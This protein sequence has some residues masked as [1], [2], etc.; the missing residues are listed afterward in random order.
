MAKRPKKNKTTKQTPATEPTTGA[1]TGEGGQASSRI[2]DA[3]AA[4]SGD[5][6]DALE[7]T[8]LAGDAVVDGP[9]SQQ[10]SEDVSKGDR[11]EAP[12]NVDMLTKEPLLTLVAVIDGE[13]NIRGWDME[14][15]GQVSVPAFG[16]RVL[17]EGKA[18]LGN[19]QFTSTMIARLFN[20]PDNVAARQQR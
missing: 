17:Q 10:A 12:L 8:V 13:G 1:T 9:A 3:P 6:V 15:N 7:G 11:V 16:A 19:I 5:D 4:R 2:E 18:M 14:W 20:H